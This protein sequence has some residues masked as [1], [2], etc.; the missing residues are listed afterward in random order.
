MNRFLDAASF[1]TIFPIPT[2][3]VPSPEMMGEA[4]VFFPFVGAIL[5]LLLFFLAWGLA[6][7]FPVTVLAIVLVGALIAMT[8]GLHWDGLADT[9]DG[10]AGAR[11]E[12]T[13]M[14]EIMKDSR[15]GAIGVLSLVFFMIFKV[16]LLAG[17]PL[18]HWKA[19]LILMPM[20]GRFL[21]VELAA[22]GNYA[23]ADEGT[24]KAFVEGVSRKDFYVAL[25]GVIFLSVL[26]A[27]WAGVGIV[28]ACILYGFG[29]KSFFDR[30]LGG[31]T[32]DI[33]GM[34]NETG[35]IFVLI[36]FYFFF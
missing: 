6:S 14:L 23:R 4:M 5:G 34:V 9:F 11:G 17:L 22:W 32:G 2:R 21:Q 3:G 33:L 35:E 26:E 31:V 18:N 13:R 25:G 28:L 30:K 24:G 29:V 8:G 27:G 15:I 1:L 10:L 20:M 19:A 36:L 12:K 7:I 16:F